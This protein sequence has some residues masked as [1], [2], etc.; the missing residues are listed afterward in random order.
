MRKK[1]RDM[2]Q[3]PQPPAL[4]DWACCEM[5]SP[6]PAAFEREPFTVPDSSQRVN[7]LRGPDVKV[8]SPL[9]GKSPGGR[10]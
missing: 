3:Q 2:A 7:R 4:D 1:P 6:V 5:D 9:A 8:E 10:V